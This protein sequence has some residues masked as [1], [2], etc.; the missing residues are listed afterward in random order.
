MVIAVVGAGKEA[1]GSRKV[2]LWQFGTCF[3]YC[4]V[5]EGKMATLRG[6]VKFIAAEESRLVKWQ[7]GEEAVRAVQSSL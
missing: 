3:N 7:L 4:R 6:I 1:V 5:R 2:V